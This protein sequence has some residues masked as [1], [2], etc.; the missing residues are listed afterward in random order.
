MSDVNFTSYPQGLPAD[1]VKLH[2]GLTLH[3]RSSDAGQIPVVF[4][5]DYPFS[6]AIWEKAQILLSTRYRSYA[7]DLRGFGLSDKPDEGY[8]YEELAADL[9]LFMKGI[10]VRQAVFVGH[11]LGGIIVQHLAVRYPNRVLAMVLTG[12]RAPFLSTGDVMAQFQTILAGSTDGDSRKQGLQ[13]IAALNFD[14]ANISREDLEYFVNAGAMAGSTALGKVLAT[15]CSSAGMGREELSA[16]VKVPTLFVVGTRDR[17]ASFEHT[18][19]LSDTIHRSRITVMARC[20]H[21]PMWE[22]PIEFVKGVAD[23]LGDN[24]LR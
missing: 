9:D 12:T 10:K 2:N 19:A 17:I 15:Y 21:S 24:G 7:P 8:G 18:V 4:V 1:R 6:S 14:R 16:G 13:E 11:G 20:G 22:K 23:F 3:F 5:H